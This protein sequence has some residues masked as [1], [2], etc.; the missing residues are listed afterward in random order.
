MTGKSNW[1]AG[2]VIAFL[3]P[4]SRL[5]ASP[6]NKLSDEISQVRLNSSNEAFRTGGATMNDAVHFLREHTALAICFESLDYDQAADDKLTL[7]EVVE[8]FRGLKAGHGLTVDDEARFKIY[9]A[10][11]AKQSLATVI[12]VKMKT[13]TLVQDHMKVREILDRL[14]QLDNAYVW[15]NDGSDTAPLIVIRPRATSVLDWSVPKICGSPEGTSSRVLYG[16]KGNLTRLFAGHRIAEVEVI[17][18]PPIA[19]DQIGSALPDVPLI[20]CR[21]RLNAKDVLNLTAKA[22]GFRLPYPMIEIMRRC[23]SLRS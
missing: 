23:F 19:A 1:L 10:M 5:H 13:F 22:A 20:L 8:G 9:E 21:D 6:P 4:L 17:E 15:E 12:G 14:T 2:V 3:L 18:S 7:G 11:A 16:P